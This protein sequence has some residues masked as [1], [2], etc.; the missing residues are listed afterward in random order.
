[1]CW[2]KRQWDLGV[3]GITACPWSERQSAGCTRDGIRPK[4]L[5]SCFEG[6]RP[7][8]RA[9]STHFVHL[10]HWFEVN[11]HQRTLL[12][13]NPT[14]HLCR[15]FILIPVSVVKRVLTTQD[16]TKYTRITHVSHDT[17]MSFCEGAL[18]RPIYRISGLLLARSP[19]GNNPSHCGPPG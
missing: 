9:R 17:I 11:L 4:A 3:S 12:P 18:T 8:T 2:D 13:F 10:Y 6:V 7:K 16:R 1:M 5:L 14:E 19:H 15:F